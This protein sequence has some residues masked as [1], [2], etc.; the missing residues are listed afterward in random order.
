M[1]Q[2]KNPNLS[3]GIGPTSIKSVGITHALKQTGLIE[4]FNLKIAKEYQLKNY[5]KATLSLNGMPPRKE[6]EL[7]HVT[8]HNQAL[9]ELLDTNLLNEGFKKLN[10]LI[11][12]QTFPPETFQNLLI[13]YI[14]H[15]LYNLAADVLAENSHVDVAPLHATKSFVKS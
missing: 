13:S 11:T 10:F 8:L 12:Q 7:D 4:A 6:S 3:V 1:E 15:N 2:K 9:L 5:Q 14:K